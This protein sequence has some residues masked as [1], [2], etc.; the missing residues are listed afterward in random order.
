MNQTQ[1]QTA[2]Y[3]ESHFSLSDSDL[4]Q[5]YNFLLETE[6]PQTVGALADLV[7]K[8]RVREQANELRR[9]MSGRTVYQ[10]QRAYEVGEELIFPALKLAQGKVTAIR[11]GYNPE[12][13]EFS[14]ISVEIK[15]KTREFAADFKKQ[16]PLNANN[17]AELTAQM[18]GDAEVIRRAYGATVTAKIEAALSGREDFIH[19]GDQWF[20]QSL[21]ADINIGHLHLTEAILEVANGGPLTMAEIA[22]QLELDPGIDPEVQEFSLTRHLLQDGRFD[23][24]SPQGPATWYLRRMEPEGV[25]TTPERLQYQPIPY[26]RALLTPQQL[27]LE[28]EL[29]DE[30]SDLP[31]GDGEGTAVLTLAYPH[32]WAGTL[33]LN[34]K[35]RP[36]FALE[37]SPRQRIVL[38]DDETKAAMEC[39]VVAEGRYIYGLGDWYKE[40]SIPVGGFI[41]LSPGPGPGVLTLGYDRRRPQREWVRLAVV[42]DNRLQFELTRRNIPC[43]Y[44]DLLIVGTDVVTA[45]DSHARRAASMQTS[46]AA[47][48]MEVF[49]SLAGLS[50]Q[51]TVHA[52]TL[53]SA[54]NMLR[55]VPP[56]PIFAELMRNPSFKAVGDHYWQYEGAA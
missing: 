7:I 8:H 20:V 29:D 10:P 25:Q 34:S 13:G 16:H 5:I 53:Y 43:G 41:H 19:I 28:Q 27:L 2:E 23:E 36:F 44:D 45:V 24:V 9:V 37:R 54:V 14:V 50:P 33:P 31:L 52:K 32:R 30:W 46:L 6:K 48:L 51:N 40:N 12:Y 56:G 21:M 3:W 26:D 47:H 42:K 22:P 38:V 17:G 55:R 39:W 11:S 49:P 18:A 35:T 1:I 15:G 4:E